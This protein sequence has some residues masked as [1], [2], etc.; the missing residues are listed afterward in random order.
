MRHLQGISTRKAIAHVYTL[1]NAF[2][3]V[4]GRNKERIRN[5]LQMFGVP[6]SKVK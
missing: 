2:D 5:N 6:R 3:C 4:P 1:D